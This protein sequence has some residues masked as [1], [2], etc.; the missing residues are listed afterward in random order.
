M[1]TDNNHF[2][3]PYTSRVLSKPAFRICKKKAQINCAVAAQLISAFVL[4]IE[5]VQSIYILNPKFQASGHLLW[6]YSQ[7]CVT[8]LETP[9]TGFLATRLKLQ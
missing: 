8:W 6:L 2:V 3:P 5:I 1:A 9:K 4:A 7:V